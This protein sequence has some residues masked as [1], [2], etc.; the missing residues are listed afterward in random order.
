MYG[1]EI[2]LRFKPPPSVRNGITLDF[3]IYSVSEMNA[4]RRGDADCS[5]ASAK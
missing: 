1:S 4:A 3:F 2:C 5:M